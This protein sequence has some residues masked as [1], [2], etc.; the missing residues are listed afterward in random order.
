MAK[1]QLIPEYTY[2]YSL[3]GFRSTS[4]SFKVA[5][6]LNNILKIN[7]AKEDDIIIDEKKSGQ[8]HYIQY[9]FITENSSFRLIKNK[10]IES[11]ANNILFL[12]SGFKH[13]DYILQ[14]SGE[15]Y[16][17]NFTDIIKLIRTIGEVEFVTEIDIKKLN[18]RIKDIFLI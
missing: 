8:I 7:L 3:I 2:D 6:A 10:N 15:I 12:L 17:H 9:S 1:K 11:E 18:N 14:I 5:W 16:P 13:L 4:R